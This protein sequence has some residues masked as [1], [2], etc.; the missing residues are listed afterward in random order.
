[1]PT[2]VGSRLGSQAPARPYP[3]VLFAFVGVYGLASALLDLGLAGGAV[4]YAEALVLLVLLAAGVFVGGILEAQA[5]GQRL[6]LALTIP[7]ALTIA[8]LSFEALTQPMLNPLFVYVL[9]AGTLLVLG[10]RSEAVF[11]SRALRPARLLRTIPI[12]A[13]LAMGLAVLGTVLPIQGGPVPEGPTWFLLAVL[14][15]AVLV[16]ELWFRGVLQGEV[17]GATSAAWG[18]L[19]TA[20][21]FAAYGAPF[22][23]LSAFLVR[24][25]IGI[26]LGA[27][28]IRRENVAATLIARALMV[29]ALVAFNPALTGT[30]VVI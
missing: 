23:G 22:G 19:A 1:M 8:R 10:P 18:W 12:G 20:A 11:G 17:A 30:S 24:L 21:I 9:L 29:A 15:P 2:G 7:P 26:V 25:V 3:L 16:D 28:A 6:F 27:L 4:V 14:V 13:G 5:S